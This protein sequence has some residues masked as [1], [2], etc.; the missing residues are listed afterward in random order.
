MVRV[1]YIY[2]RS[3]MAVLGD[4]Q[5][6]GVFNFF[7]E[8][9]GIPH[10]S[11]DTYKISEYLVKFAEDRNLVYRRDRLN[12]VIIFK[13][14]SQGYENSEPV[15]IQGHMDM[16]CEKEPDC[17][18]NFKEDGLKLVVDKDSISAVGTTLGGDDGIALAYAL[19]IL[20]DDSI[21]H[22]P[23]E[24]VFTVDEE[25][26]MLG[27]AGLSCSDLKGRV[28]LNLDSEDEGYLL[29]S[30]AGGVCVNA[31]LPVDYEASEDRALVF[32]KIAGASGGHSGV[33]I[34]KQR[35]NADKIMGRF[36]HG[37][38]KKMDIRL[39]SVEGGLKDNAIPVKSTAIIAVK[40]SEIDVFKSQ[41]ENVFAPIKKEFENTDPELHLTIEASSELL[42]ENETKKNETENSLKNETKPTLEIDSAEKNETKPVLENG[43]AD[44]NKTKSTLKNNNKNRMMTKSSHDRVIKAL[45][46]VPNGVQKMSLD[47]ENLVQTSLNLGILKTSEKTVDFVFSVRSSVSD[48]KNYVVQQLCCIMDTLGGYVELCGDYPAW[49]YRKDSPLRDLMV[50]IFKE[51]YGREPVIQALHAGVECGLFSGKLPGLDC[52]SF[53]PD[54]KDIHTT[55]ETLSISSVER[56]WRYLLEILKRL[57]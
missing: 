44:E 2:R 30:C 52:V 10:G 26:G 6:K 31:H 14:G 11:S 16:V 7:E 40:K 39:V 46:I 41:A 13:E 43:S 29:V 45:F 34:D 4:L 51:Q 56:C 22:P 32:V 18:I 19:A 1:K 24:C 28:M 53:G 9:C 50:E 42:L 20:D 8:I 33:E 23:L 17:D 21:P 12:N 47:I 57:R 36:L 15:I 5:P 3:S 38:D 27:A 25:I 54:I 55:R 37:V 35:A 48:E 49:E